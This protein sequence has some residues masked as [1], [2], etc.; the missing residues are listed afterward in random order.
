MVGVGVAE[1]A[2]LISALI[3]KIVAL[4]APRGGQM[5]FILVFAGVLSSVA[6]DAGYIVLIP[7]GPQPLPGPGPAPPGRPG[8]PPSPG[9]APSSGCNLLITPLD[10]VLTE[11]TNDAIHTRQSLR[12]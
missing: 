9:S 3:R 10:G 2:G 8:G 11:I 12:S 1:E 4:V 5:T 7:L 6:S